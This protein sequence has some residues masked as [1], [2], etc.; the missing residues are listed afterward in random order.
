MS[1]KSLAE[2]VAIGCAAVI[3]A[4]SPGVA[5]QQ[6][7]MPQHPAADQAGPGV[8]A[9]EHVM[10]L[11]RN[12]MMAGMQAAD[13]RLDG[14]VATMNAASG[15]DQVEATAKVVTEMV[16]Q[17]RA[18]RDGMMAMQARMM[19]HM[20]EHMQAGSASMASCPMMKM[21]DPKP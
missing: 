4:A 20:M 13:L 7:A 11:E 17:R 19:S 16:A 21:G 15:D 6:P 5:G 18:M 14:L 1:I 8:T 9:K 12:N 10:M 2:V 3:I